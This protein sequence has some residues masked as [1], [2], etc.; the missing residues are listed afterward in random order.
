MIDKFTAGAGSLT[1]YREHGD[2]FRLLETGAKVTVYIYRHGREIARADEISGGYAEKFAE[3]FDEI[4]I[5]SAV[6]QDVQFAIRLGNVVSYDAP[7]TGSVTVANVPHVQVDSIPAVTVSGSIRRSFFQDSLAIGVVN[8]SLFIAKPT[9]DYLFIQNTSVSA[10]IFVS[11]DS[12]PATVARGI[13]LEPGASLELDSVLPTGEIT[14]IA[15]AAG[16]TVT[17][18]QAWG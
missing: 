15:D 11:L 7:P 5:E 1:V 3:P 16:A 10:N 18:V 4:A 13:K 12:S 9:R 17:R 14:A 2:F 8:T 6:A